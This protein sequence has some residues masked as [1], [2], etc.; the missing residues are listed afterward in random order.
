MQV[1]EGHKASFCLEDN[2]C[3]D[4]VF[5]CAD[6]GEQGISPGCTDVYYNNI[7]CQA[8]QLARRWNLTQSK[9]V[10]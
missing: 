10:V 9:R 4:G 2:Q 6:Y 1:V 5:A 3:E 8:S 7:D